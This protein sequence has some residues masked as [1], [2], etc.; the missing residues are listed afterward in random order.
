M[1]Y[2]I[3]IRVK[4]KWVHKDMPWYGWGENKKLYNLRTNRPVTQTR[5][6]GSI[7]YWMNRKFFTIHSLKNKLIKCKLK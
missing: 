5:N 1:G 2:Y 7:G 4:I 3:N 6:G